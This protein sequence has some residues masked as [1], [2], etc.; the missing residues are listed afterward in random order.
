VTILRSY[1]KLSK[2]LPLKKKKKKVEVEGKRR[3]EEVE[4]KIIEMKKKNDA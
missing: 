4:A 3:D 1:H 2:K